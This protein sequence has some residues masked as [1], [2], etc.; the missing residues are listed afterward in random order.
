[1]NLRFLFLFLAVLAIIAGV[2]AIFNENHQIERLAQIS[3]LFFLFGYHAGRLRDPGNNFYGFFI[4]LIIANI[5]V[6]LEDFWY[7][8]YLS[9][10]FCLIAFGFL[11][12]EAVNYIQ[13]NRGSWY[14]QLFFLFV[15][16][17][18]IYFVSLQLSEVAEDMGSGLS[19]IMYFVYYFSLFI[20]GITALVYYLNSYSRKS[21]YFTCFV[22][23]LIFSNILRDLGD[24]YLKDISVEIAGAL[25]QFAALKFVFLFFVT[26]E[27]KL[28]LLHMV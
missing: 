17:F 1:M 7:F 4:M 15:V 8:S 3:F 10:I 25:M 5:C 14:M 16:G 21:L 6:V 23:S 26:K 19:V 12:K 2:V 20:L 13:Y 18:F 22:L 24:F 9:I 27:K 11:I 28:S